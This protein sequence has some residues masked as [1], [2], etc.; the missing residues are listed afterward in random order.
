MAAWLFLDRLLPG[1]TEKRLNEAFASYG[2]VKRTLLFKNSTGNP[3][4]FIEMAADGDASKAAQTVNE[5]NLLG[6]RSR[7]AIVPRRMPAGVQ[8]VID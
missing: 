6:E 7:A 1:I 8:R 3:V 2:A 5:G 4:A